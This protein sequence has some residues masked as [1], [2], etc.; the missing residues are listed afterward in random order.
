MSDGSSGGEQWFE[1]EFD[2]FYANNNISFWWYDLNLNGN[3]AISQY[4]HRFFSFM[5]LFWQLRAIWFCIFVPLLRLISFDFF[6][7]HN[8]NRHINLS[9]RWNEKLNLIFFSSYYFS[10]KCRKSSQ[11]SWVEPM[12]SHGDFACKVARILERHSWSRRWVEVEKL[13]ISIWSCHMLITPRKLC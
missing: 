13:K 2:E 7:S 5:W 6:L 11:L 12:A 8:R 9:I 10:E 1:I 4:Q 3:I